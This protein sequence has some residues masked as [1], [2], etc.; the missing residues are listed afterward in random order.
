V[1]AYAEAVAY[2][3]G[4]EV[5]RGWDLSLDRMRAALALRG[6][7]ERAFAA[8]HVAGTNGKGSTAAMLEA[9][10]RAGRWRTG[11]Y[12]SPHLVEFT[13]RI[14]A[15]GRMIPRGVVATGVTAL[16][17]VLAKA[18]LALTHFEFATLLAFEWFA[19]IGVEAAV[20]EVG[21]GGRLDAT[22]VIDPVCCVVTSIARDHEAFLGTRLEDIAAEKAGIVKAGVPVCVGRLVPEAAA[23]VAARA[24]ALQAPLARAGDDG[25]LV[26]AGAG[27]AFR[28]PG[29]EWDD[30]HVA[31]RGGF[32]Q[33]N[34]EVALLAL[35]RVRARWPVA[36]DAVRAG[37]ASVV[38]PGRL[39][40]VRHRPVVVVDGAH[41]P[42]AAQALAVEL[43]RA[44]GGRPTTLVFAA[45]RDK[46]WAEEIEC[47]L[48]HV[49]HVVLTRVGRR[50]EDPAQLAAAVA[51]RRPAVVCEDPRIAFEEGIARA[52]P[53][54]AV[55]VTGSLFLVGE[56]YAALGGTPFETWHGWEGDGT[57]A[58]R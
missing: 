10:L 20:I 11:L 55:L 35:A 45:M 37:L 34:A 57:E 12:T 52:R 13:E 31:L 54:G 16:R 1:N 24:A 40:V 14:R 3:R 8:I 46:S 29:V 48:P 58:R 51:G 36:A 19:R 23:V 6:N 30:L 25:V 43:P 38:W 7:P 22:N 32:Q 5:A 42:A 56:V 41:N 21:L 17:D 4:L 47:L 49:A 2:L 18:G 15:G 28:A 44:L 33:D 26:P 27:L 50:G 9:C 39:A 53:E